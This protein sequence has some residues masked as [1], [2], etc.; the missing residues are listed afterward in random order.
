MS[1]GFKR[2]SLMCIKQFCVTQLTAGMC[3]LTVMGHARTG[4]LLIPCWADSMCTVP[5]ICQH[6]KDANRFPYNEL[7][8]LEH[9]LKEKV[10]DSCLFSFIQHVHV[11]LSCARSQLCIACYCFMLNQPTCQKDQGKKVVAAP[12]IIKV[13]RTTY[14]KLY[15]LHTLAQV[16]S[17]QSLIK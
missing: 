11:F 13:D 4:F 10:K 6:V 17:S 12:K 2:F 5:I 16:P 9:Q 3:Y 7:T 15:H 1:V 14:R 8:G